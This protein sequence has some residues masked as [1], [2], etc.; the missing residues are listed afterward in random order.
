MRVLSL[1]LIASSA[2]VASAGDLSRPAIAWYGAWQQGLAE[3]QRSNRPILL[4]AGAPHCHG[5][6]GLW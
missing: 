1:L 3:A 4:V 5:I 2:T 6:S